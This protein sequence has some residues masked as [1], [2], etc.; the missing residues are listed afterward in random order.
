LR[1][2]RL[3]RIAY[4]VDENDHVVFSTQSDQIKKCKKSSKIMNEKIVWWIGSLWESIGE[5]REQM[6]EQ[7][8]K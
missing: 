8:G 4:L 1:F 2:E 7:Y 5:A 6:I 3:A